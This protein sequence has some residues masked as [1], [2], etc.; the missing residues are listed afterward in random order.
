[1]VIFLV[2]ALCLQL[3]ISNTN[4]FSVLATVSVLPSGIVIASHHLVKQSVITSSWVFPLSVL[5][6]RPHKSTAKV[7]HSFPAQ[8]WYCHCGSCKTQTC[9]LQTS[10]RPKMA[11][12]SSIYLQKNIIWENNSQ[13]IMW[14]VQINLISL[15]DLFAHYLKQSCTN[16]SHFTIGDNN[17]YLQSVSPTT[18][19]DH[20]W[21]HRAVWLEVCVGK[22]RKKKSCQTR[23]KQIRSYITRCNNG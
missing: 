19:A 5:G 14:L 6:N 23:G 17:L 11:P 3:S 7:C 16:N 4:S 18:F 21:K 20:I 9:R 13:Q 15:L 10:C 22:F 8:R 12:K 2:T 1:M